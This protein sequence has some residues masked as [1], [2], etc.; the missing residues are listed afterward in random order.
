MKA[1]FCAI[2]AALLLGSAVR[3]ETLFA[4]ASVATAARLTP[5]R[6]A[7]LRFIKEQAAASRFELDASRLALARS[8]SPAVRSLAGNLVSRNNTLG[9]ELA[10]LLHSRGMAAPMLA[11][12]Q[13]KTLNRLNKLAGSRFDKAYLEQ[14]A[15]SQ[16]DAQREFGKAS[17]VLHDP[18]VKAWIDR[19][20]VAG[21][22]PLPGAQAALP[23][24]FSGS[25]TR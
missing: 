17:L 6:K 18:Q 2:A 21:S 23:V 3:A 5:E 14:M 15:Q 4:A 13:R 24:R 12:D 25:N 19:T 1:A 7:E 20:L 10:H 9:L 16:R 11:N 8:T 22:A